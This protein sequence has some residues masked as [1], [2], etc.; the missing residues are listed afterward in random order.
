MFVPDFFRL[1]FVLSEEQ[2]L[3]M[4]M[5][6]MTLAAVFIAAALSF[7]GCGGGR[8]QEGVTEQAPSAEKA[9]SCLLF[10]FDPVQ[11]T[12][13]DGNVRSGEFFSTLLMK[14]GMSVGDATAG[15]P[16]VNML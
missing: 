14:L 12:V 3:R 13:R 2:R 10:G 11:M 5:K 6:N 15:R 4:N 8:S 16:V 1:N 7:A 9:D